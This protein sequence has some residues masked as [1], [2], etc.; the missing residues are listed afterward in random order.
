LLAHTLTG[1]RLVDL[2]TSDINSFPASE[3]LHN[4]CF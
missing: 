4:A 1:Y 3:M 2:K